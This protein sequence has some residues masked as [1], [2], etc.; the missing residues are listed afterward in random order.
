MTRPPDEEF[1]FERG[2]VPRPHGH[3]MMQLVV[4]GGCETGGDR[5]QALALAGSD[6]ARDI[7]RAHAPAGRMAQ[8]CQKGF[9]P[10]LESALPIL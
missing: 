10:G 5:L 6:Q 4:V 1:G 8:M 9:Q 3:E 2:L 7:E